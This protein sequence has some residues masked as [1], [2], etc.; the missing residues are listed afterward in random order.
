MAMHD[1]ERMK[2]RVPHIRLVAV[3]LVLL[4]AVILG[5]SV[6]PIYRQHAIVSAFRA[7]GFDV[8]VVEGYP[9]GWLDPVLPTSVRQSVYTAWSDAFGEVI[10]VAGPGDPGQEFTDRDFST[11]LALPAL[12]DLNVGHSLITDAGLVQLEKMPQLKYLLLDNTQ[13]GDAGVAHLRNLTNLKVLH[14][15][16]TRITEEMEDLRKLSVQKTRVTKDGVARLRK[17]LPDLSQ[18]ITVLE[19]VE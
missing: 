9:P 7:R 10:A 1:K 18:V 5:F 19:G 14:L 2:R 11:L 12:R 13:I 3:A 17:A 16:N 6:R 15:G 8:A 4:L